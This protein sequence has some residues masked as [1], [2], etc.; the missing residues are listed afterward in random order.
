MTI[1]TTKTTIITK[2]TTTDGIGRINW[3]IQ[4]WFGNETI[5][6]QIKL[7]LE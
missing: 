5:R 7:P 3:V 6:A 2:T 1:T 4:K